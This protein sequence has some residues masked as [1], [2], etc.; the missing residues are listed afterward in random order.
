MDLSDEPFDQARY[1][2][3]RRGTRLTALAYRIRDLRL[4]APIGCPLAHFIHQVDSTDGAIDLLDALVQVLEEQATRTR[5]QERARTS[6][7]E[8]AMRVLGRVHDL[9]FALRR[10]AAR[11]L[12][13]VGD[14]RGMELGNEPIT[15][16]A[17]SLVVEAMADCIEEEERFIEQA[18]YEENE[19]LERE[20]DH[21]WNRAEAFHGDLNDALRANEVLRQENTQLRETIAELATP[22]GPTSI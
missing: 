1:D 12:W 17:L 7:M 2:A 22:G 15:I 8:K 4:E 10:N 9:D 16:H 21:A 20:V 3:D 19:E 6:D 18:I 14:L 13:L 11:R 5:K